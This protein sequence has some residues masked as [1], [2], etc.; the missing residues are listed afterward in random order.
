M[1]LPAYIPSDVLRDGIVWFDKP[2][3]K[4]K[5][6]RLPESRVEDEALG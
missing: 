1:K 2:I 4:R 3:R 6:P 5:S